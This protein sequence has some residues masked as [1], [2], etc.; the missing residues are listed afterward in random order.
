MNIDLLLLFV[1]HH[2][3]VYVEALYEIFMNGENHKWSGS[4][5]VCRRNSE[6]G[7]KT[8]TNF[9]QF[10]F[11]CFSKITITK[12]NI[13]NCSTVKMHILYMN[14]HMKNI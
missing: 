9:C 10:Q 13:T 8:P 2:D 12:W 6:E 7:K 4:G 14:V 5:I 3:F 1:F 11:S